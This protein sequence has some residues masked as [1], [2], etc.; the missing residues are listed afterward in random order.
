MRSAVLLVLV[1][2]LALVSSV[3]ARSRVDACFDIGN[4]RV[5]CENSYQMLDGEVSDCVYCIAGA[6]PPV[7]VNGQQAERLPPGVFECLEPEHVSLMD[8]VRDL[9]M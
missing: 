5:K 7:C 4:N 6:V 3:A 9:R 2:V 8:L 1:A